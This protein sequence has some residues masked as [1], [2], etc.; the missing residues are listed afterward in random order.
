VLSV[1]LDL[2]LDRRPISGRLRTEQ[3]GVAHRSTGR[4]HKRTHHKRRARRLAT[5]EARLIR[6]RERPYRHLA[7]GDCRAHAG[8]P[9]RRHRRLAAARRL[10]RSSHGFAESRTRRLADPGTPARS[11]RSIGARD[12]GEPRV[13]MRSSRSSLPEPRDRLSIDRDR[14]GPFQPKRFGI[15]HRLARWQP[16]ES[17]D[18]PAENLI[19]CNGLPLIRPL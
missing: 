13:S 19:A 7:L 16:D 4:G 9:S 10:P 15:G 14:A 8:R 2:D 3:R 17:E 1:R 11:W 6:P 18:Y 5:A 12:P